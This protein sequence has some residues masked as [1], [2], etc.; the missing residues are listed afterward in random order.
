MA[1]RRESRTW[2]DSLVARHAD[3]FQITENGQT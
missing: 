2:R 3:I 1:V